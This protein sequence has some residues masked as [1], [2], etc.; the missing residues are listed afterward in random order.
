MFNL[1]FFRI[2]DFYLDCIVRRLLILILAL[3]LFYQIFGYLVVFNL[4]TMLCTK[5]AKRIIKAGLKE[6]EM[7]SFRFSSNEY[8]GINLQNKKEFKHQNNLYDVVRTEN[9]GQDSI[10]VYCIND[11]KETE[12]FANL[13]AHMEQS[14][15]IQATGKP[16]SKVIMKLI[17]IEGLLIKEE[18]C[19]LFTALE[20]PYIK[21]NSRIVTQ[22]FTVSTPPP[23]QFLCKL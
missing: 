21:Y 19:V 4:N 14:S 6:E 20:I 11:E 8:A 22:I 3:S 13:A 5:E 9:I 17:K 10:L 7:T 15:D 18:N 2:L 12:L 16:I 1:F 23:E